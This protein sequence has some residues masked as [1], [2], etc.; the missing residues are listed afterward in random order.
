MRLD[1]Q[2]KAGQKKKQQ[3]EI[4]FINDEK[5]K[6]ELQ[7]IMTREFIRFVNEQKG[8]TFLTKGKK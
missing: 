7:D 6:E 5:P 8:F 2:R 3:F 4:E 1:H